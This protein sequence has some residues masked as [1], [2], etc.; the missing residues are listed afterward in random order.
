MVADTA[1]TGGYRKI[2]LFRRGELAYF[3]HGFAKSD[4][5]NLRPDE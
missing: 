1:S 3:V 4:G 2:V 5:E